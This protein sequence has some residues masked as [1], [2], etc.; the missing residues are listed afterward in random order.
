MVG[1]RKESFYIS[2]FGED[3]GKQKYKKVVDK[4]AVRDTR[5]TVDFVANEDAIT[6]GDAVKCCACGK[7]FK[8]ITRTHLK[9]NCI[10]SITSKEYK[11]KYPSAD[12][13]ARNLN[14]LFSNTEISIKEKYGEEVGSL[15]W[16]NYQ[17]IQ[18]ETNTFEYK[19]KKYNM[20]KEEFDSYNKKRSCTL[21]NFIE[22]YGE[23]IG[24][25]K[26]DEYCERQRY[27][28]TVDYFIEKYGEEIGEERWETFYRERVESKTDRVSLQETC[29]FNYLIDNGIILTQQ[30]KIRD[31]RTSIYDFVNEERKILIEYNGDV[32]HM[33]PSRYVAF[34]IQP[35]TKFLASEVWA[36]DAIKRKRAEDAGYSLYIIWEQDWKKDKV[37]ILKEIREFWDEK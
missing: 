1:F 22:R 37:K 10:E 35:R 18:A 34:D 15:K 19:A 6:N 2:K 25:D 9:N 14:K 11:T 29:A 13:T 17:D 32:W 7:I 24:I 28:T 36:R 31:G 4:R 16:K 5:R 33:N 27:T 23:E 8:R 20:S 3:V 26:W 12:I 30:F 21:E